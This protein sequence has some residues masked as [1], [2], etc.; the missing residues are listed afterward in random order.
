MNV[1]DQ[2]TDAVHAQGC[3]RILSRPS[4]LLERYHF[5][6]ECRRHVLEKD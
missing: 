1:T 2:A 4:L 5:C 6:P 3:S